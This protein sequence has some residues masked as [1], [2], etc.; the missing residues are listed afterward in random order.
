VRLMLASIWF[1]IET[2]PSGSLRAD[3]VDGERG[4]GNVLHAGVAIVRRCPASRHARQAGEMQFSAPEE[5]EGF[6]GGAHRPGA[7][8][9]EQRQ[10]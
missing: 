4:V 2:T 10:E 3:R 5:R 9:E 7:A 6:V 1:A 8:A